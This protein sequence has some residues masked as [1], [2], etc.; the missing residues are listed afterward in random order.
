MDAKLKHDPRILY[1]DRAFM[2]DN[3]EIMVKSVIVVAIPNEVIRHECAAQS[4]N[5]L[6]YREL[7]DIAVRLNLTEAPPLDNAEFDK[8]GTRTIEVG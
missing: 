4:K 5:E 2:N 7:Y 6:S 1:N 3:T 8:A